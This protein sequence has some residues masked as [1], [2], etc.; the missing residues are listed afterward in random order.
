MLEAT[1]TAAWK[2]VLN[3]LTHLRGLAVNNQRDA[4]Q[5]DQAPATEGKFHLVGLRM[6]SITHMPFR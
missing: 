3:L 5:F 6:L 2:S 1:G 4:S